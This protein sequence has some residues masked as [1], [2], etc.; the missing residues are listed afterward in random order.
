MI[1]VLLPEYH[2][3]NRFME[4]EALFTRWV[5]IQSPWDQRSGHLAACARRFP[6]ASRQSRKQG[7]W[8][9][10]GHGSILGIRRSTDPS[11]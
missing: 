7:V 5:F 3:D 9:Q 1:A 2:S 6:K 4:I 10:E 11:A 8:P